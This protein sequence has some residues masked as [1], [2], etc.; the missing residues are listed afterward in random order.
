MLL[1]MKPCYAINVLVTLVS[2]NQ[3]EVEMGRE[4]NALNCLENMHPFI[5]WERQ[6]TWGMFFPKKS[7]HC[8]WFED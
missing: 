1:I 3:V 8:V 7:N 6:D 2:Y 4:Y 5:S